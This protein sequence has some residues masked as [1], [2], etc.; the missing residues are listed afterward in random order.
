MLSRL[1][2]LIA[3]VVRREKF[4]L[5]GATHRKLLKNKNKEA[6]PRRAQKVTK[7]TGNKNRECQDKLKKGKTR[8][9]KRRAGANV[10]TRESPGVVFVFGEW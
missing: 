7:N 6:V 8:E 4:K 10:A 1:T 3:T 5:R 9:H 2:Y